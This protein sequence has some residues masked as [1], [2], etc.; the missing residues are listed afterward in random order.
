MQEG[1]F[2]KN[3]VTEEKNVHEYMM[4]TEMDI[5]YAN[6]EILPPKDKLKIIIIIKYVDLQ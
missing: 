5:T 1:K 3:I 2:K 4:F 6:L